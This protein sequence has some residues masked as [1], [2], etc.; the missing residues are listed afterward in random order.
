MYICAWVAIKAEIITTCT[1]QQYKNTL[2]VSDGLS[3]HHKEFKTVHTA[4]DTVVCSLAS[5][6]QYLFDIYLLLYAQSWTP[7][8]GR[9]DR[10]KHV[11][12]YSKIKQI[13]ETDASSW[14]YYRNALYKLKHLITTI[15]CIFMHTHMKR[16]GS[17]CVRIRQTVSIMRCFGLWS[18]LFHDDRGDRD[19][20]QL[21]FIR[22]FKNHYVVRNVWTIFIK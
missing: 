7:D 4:T 16:S 1:V 15:V 13:W 10:P 18:E 9:K 11:E 17:N 12:C 2:H 20:I 22:T 14:F 8:D 19:A 5:R 6:Q 21:D 3:V